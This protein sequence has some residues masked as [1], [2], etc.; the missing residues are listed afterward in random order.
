MEQYGTSF[1]P[2]VNFSYEFFYQLGL[3][4]FGNFGKIEFAED[5]NI[6]ELLE[7]SMEE[8]ESDGMLQ[9][10]QADE[11]NVTLCL[12]EELI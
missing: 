9:Q 11:I 4:E 3:A 10:A 2:F 12:H 8:V 7:L 1:Y 5:L 6:R